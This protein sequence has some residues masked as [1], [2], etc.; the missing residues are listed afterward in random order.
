MPNHAVAG[1]PIVE[2]AK[3]VTCD[4][5]GTWCYQHGGES[6]GKTFTNSRLACQALNGDL[7]WWCAAG[8]Y[9]SD[10]PAALVTGILAHSARLGASC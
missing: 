4:N 2:N 9:R 10:C 6:S 8:L 3:Y 1:A 5:N 7:V